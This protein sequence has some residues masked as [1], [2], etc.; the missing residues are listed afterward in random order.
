MLPFYCTRRLDTR[1]ATVFKSI[2]S[3][4]HKGTVANSI[5]MFIFLPS[6]TSLLTQTDCFHYWESIQSQNSCFILCCQRMEGKHTGCLRYGS[7]YADIKVPQPESFSFISMT[8]CPHT[9]NASH[10]RVHDISWKTKTT[11]AMQ[12]WEFFIFSRY[13]NSTPRGGAN[14][15]QFISIS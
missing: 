9:S 14:I 11:Y 6:Q 10:Q 15:I 8:R 2:A 7:C 12:L 4:H 13:S 3:I 1:T 5:R